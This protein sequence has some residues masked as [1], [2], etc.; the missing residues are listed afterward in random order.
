MRE[1]GKARPRPIGMLDLDHEPVVEIPSGKQHDPTGWSSH[2]R[3]Y[4]C[5]KI[6][7]RM[8]PAM[9]HAEA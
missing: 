7:A 8:R 1:V 6:N 5:T 3:P 4:G 9:P 2:R